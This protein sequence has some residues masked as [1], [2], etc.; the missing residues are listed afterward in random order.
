MACPRPDRASDPT[1]TLIPDRAGNTSPQALRWA[2]CPSGAQR[3]VPPSN[4]TIQSWR[5]RAAKM[6]ALAETLKDPKTIATMHRLAEEYDALADRAAQAQ[7]SSPN[8]SPSSK[9]KK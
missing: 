5:D 7:P 2:G 3:N 4:Q 1:V 8:V 9:S 6:R